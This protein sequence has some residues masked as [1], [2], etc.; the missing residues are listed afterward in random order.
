VTGK[1]KDDY[2]HIRFPTITEASIQDRSKAD[3]FTKVFACVQSSWLIAQS[4]ARVAVGLQISQLE[5]AT[6]AFVF[7][8]LIMYILWWDKPFGVEHRT[9]VTFPT[10]KDESP[11][12]PLSQWVTLHR[13]AFQAYRKSDITTDSI[14][15]MIF[16]LSTEW[17]FGSDAWKASLAF[18]A[19]GT[20]FSAFHIAAW[21]WE[22][23]SSIDRT[24]WRTFAVASTSITPLSIAFYFLESMLSGG[25]FSRYAVNFLAF[26]TAIFA[27]MAYSISRLGLIVIIF[28][29][30]SSM[31]ASAY[32]TVEWTKYLPHFQ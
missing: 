27:T 31:P 1:L 5:L 30:F 13:S 24:L 23:P 6:M 4:I 17:R 3:V 11:P 19:T 25:A 7:C 15:E 9:I 18:Y 21:N 12:L 28:R 29:C 10:L 16:S 22:F 26:G 8:A 20:V 32:E 14:I 2:A